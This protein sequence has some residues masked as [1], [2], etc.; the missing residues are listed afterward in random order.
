QISKIEEI[1]TN[2]RL[3][4]SSFSYA[5]LLQSVC[6]S[7]HAHGLLSLQRVNNINNNMADENNVEDVGPAPTPPAPSTS[8]VNRRSRRSEFVD[9][10]ELMGLPLNTIDKLDLHAPVLELPNQPT[11][12]ERNS[13]ALEYASDYFKAAHIVDSTLLEYYQEDFDDWTLTHFDELNANVKRALKRAIR[14][15]GVYTGPNRGRSTT[16]QLHDLLVAEDLPVWP[17]DELRDQREL[18]ECSNALVQQQQLLGVTASITTSS[19]VSATPPPTDPTRRVLAPTVAPTLST[20]DERSDPR[21][22]T[23]PSPLQQPSTETRPAIRE[24]GPSDTMPY[25]SRNQR[26]VPRFTEPTADVELPD[27]RESRDRTTTPFDPGFAARTITPNSVIHRS[28]TPGRELPPR[29]Y[30]NGPIDAQKL[31]AFEKSWNKEYSFGGDLYEL[32]DDKVM[33]FYKKCRSLGIE[34]D[35]YHAVFPS[36]LKDRASRFYVR[37]V[38]DDA[39]FSETYAALKTEFHSPVMQR[40]Y[41]NELNTLTFDKLKTS[42][43]MADKTDIEVLDALFERLH[44]CQR[45]MGEDSDQGLAM[46]LIRACRQ[47]RK[48]APMMYKPAMTTH[49]LRADLRSC[50][51][52]Y[53]LHPLSAQY[54]VD[55]RYHDERTRR[56]AEKAKSP[57][58]WKKKCYARRR[59]S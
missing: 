35:Q 26:Q 47:N 1:L 29:R 14:A 49:E 38:P 13:Y 33:Q 42:P 43:E 56:H 54:P 3:D 30:A 12:G 45:G 58:N 39:T 15:G 10:I 20:I 23:P 52:A 4:S 22:L 31:T 59:A 36:V 24:K 50:I 8:P 7:D 32:L 53:D 51:E 6:S 25:I 9:R 27:D 48:F 40:Q 21:H 5:K 44:I 57:S 2:E 11:I 16:Q 37:S 41:Q 18:K 46:A 28:Q 19:A 55:R 17:N 34:P